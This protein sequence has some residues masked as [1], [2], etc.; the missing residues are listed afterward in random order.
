MPSMVQACFTPRL[1]TSD[2]EQCYEHSLGPI[3]A[4]DPIM[5]S[6]TLH[7]Y[8][9]AP[10]PFQRYM[11]EVFEAMSLVQEVSFGRRFHPHR[12]KQIVC[13]VTSWIED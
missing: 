6:S 2:L 8:H 11:L 12:H 4:R 5:P 13:Q 10:D 1:Y 9:R 3:A 7:R